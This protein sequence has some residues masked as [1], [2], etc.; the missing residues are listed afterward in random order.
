MLF[1]LHTDGSK[2]SLTTPIEVGNLVRQWKYVYIYRFI[3]PCLNTV[4]VDSEDYFGLPS[5]K[6]MQY[7]Y[8]YII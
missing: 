3:G 1:P 5:V 4:R 6:K 8:I 2:K 7:I